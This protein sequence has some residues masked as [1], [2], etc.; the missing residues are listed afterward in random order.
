M[1]VTIADYPDHVPIGLLQGCEIQRSVGPGDI[2]NYA[3]VALPE[4][5][6]SQAWQFIKNRALHQTSGKKKSH[7]AVSQPHNTT[8]SRWNKDLR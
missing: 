8:P 6:A 1:A 3:D 4:T 2:L 7:I 5:R